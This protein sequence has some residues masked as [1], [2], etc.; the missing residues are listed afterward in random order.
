MRYAVPASGAIGRAPAT[1]IWSSPFRHHVGASGP[2]LRGRAD[3][4]QHA[5]RGRDGVDVQDG[6]AGAD[7]AVGAR[8][9]PDD[10]RLLGLRQA[11]VG[12]L[13]QRGGHERRVVGGHERDRDGRREARR[14]ASTPARPSSPG[15]AGGCGARSQPE[16][17]LS[18]AGPASSSLETGASGVAGSAA[19]RSATN[20][21][22]TG[23]EQRHGEAGGHPPQARPRRPC[24]S[25]AGSSLG[26]E[27]LADARPAAL[28][29]LLRG[30]VTTRGGAA[31]GTGAA[32]CSASPARA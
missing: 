8:L 16:E 9:E 26:V 28:P 13:D 23:G 5:A 10:A 7:A 31:V 4:R 14:R 17:T 20:Q 1:V 2:P 19:I 6:V 3:D 25:P 12:L 24:G 22:P 30:G 27:G 21:P 32:G 11:A 29:L 18:R 15:S